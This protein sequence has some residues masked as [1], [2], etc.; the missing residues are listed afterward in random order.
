MCFSVGLTC[1]GLSVYALILRELG[2][3]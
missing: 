2:P 3:H 1:I